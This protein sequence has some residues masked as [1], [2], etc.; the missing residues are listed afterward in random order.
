MMGQQAALAYTMDALQKGEIQRG[1]AN[2][3][4]TQLMGVR[5]IEGS[6]PRE[7]RKELMAAVKN[8]EIGHM[9]KDGM[10]P[11]VFFHKNAGTYATEIRARHLESSINVLKKVLG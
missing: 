4:M 1:Q 9:K 3:F 8:G 2:V 6:L 11:E 5:V 10:K 7:V